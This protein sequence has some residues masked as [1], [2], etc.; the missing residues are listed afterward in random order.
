VEVHFRDATNDNQVDEMYF[1]ATRFEDFDLQ[2]HG[3]GW[4]LE[5]SK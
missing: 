3:D 5:L 4:M 1:T 2:K